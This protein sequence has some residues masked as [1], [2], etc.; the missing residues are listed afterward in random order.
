MKV[1][2][3]PVHLD[4]REILSHLMEKYN[5]EFSQWDLRD[6]NDLGLYGYQYLDYYWNEERRWAYFILAD[7]KL[8]GFALVNDLPEVDDRETDYQLA[9]F[10]VMY[11][12]RRLGVGRR[13]VFQLFDE[14]KGRWQ[15]KRHPK[16][17]AAARFWDRVINDYS[18]GSFELVIAYPGTAYHDG[19]LG[20]VYF[21]NSR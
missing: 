19:S 15:L 4:E 20:D 3:R 18:D 14:H 5:Y 8:A 10:F 13:A 9:E 11:K 16:N 6:V 12:Y 21:F 7:D 2:L 17:L 1:E